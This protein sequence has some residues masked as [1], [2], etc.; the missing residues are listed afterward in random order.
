M[1]TLRILLLTGFFIAVFLWRCSTPDHGSSVSVRWENNRATGL[2]IPNSLLRGQSGLSN[3]L[4]IQLIQSGERTPVLGEF[5][6]EDGT[7]I[8]EPLV[9]FT[10]GL[11]YEI[12]LDNVTLSEIEI[13]AGESVAP[14]LLA[15]YPSQDTVPENLLKMY[16]M[17]SQPMM[18][19]RSLAHITVLQNGDTLAGTFLDLQPELWNKEGNTL[20]LWLDPGRIKRDLIPNQEMGTPLVSGKKYTLHISSDWKSKEGAALQTSYSKTF[21]SSSRDEIIPSVDDWSLSLPS[22]GTSQS[23][24]ID[25]KEALDYS[26]LME[27]VQVYSGD[28]LVPGTIQL[29]GEEHIL[30]FTP[31]VLW[32]A[33]EYTLVV[34]SR[35]EDLAGNNLNRPF[36]RD[37]NE[38]KKADKGV[39]RK[40]F[41]VQ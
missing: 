4:K 27:A 24:K 11:R 10:K 30:V 14:E 34:E 26:V 17:F 15:I 28:T 19:G 29:T 41:K 37:V 39:F 13:P 5:K 25:L 33:S 3:R 32:K 1:S 35:V 31:D 12:V 6:S 2:L 16:F 21:V 23:L 8:F 20:T 22:S 9:P 18:E 40:L 36:D 38:R 7:T